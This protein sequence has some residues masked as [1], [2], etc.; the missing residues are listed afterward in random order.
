MRALPDANARLAN[1]AETA[2]IESATS[3]RASEPWVTAKRSGC[4]PVL[5]VGA[6]QAGLVTAVG[7]RSRGISDVTVV[8][9]AAESEAGPWT[10]YARMRTL[11][12]PKDIHWPTW[13]IPSATPRAWFEARYGHA[14][15]QAITLIPT[16]DWQAFLEWYRMTLAIAVEFETT[17]TRIVGG[18]GG[19]PFTV[20][21]SSNGSTRALRADR[22]VLATGLEGSGGRRAP[23]N[24][25]SGIPTDTWAHTHDDIGFEALAG[26]RVGILGGGTGAFDNAATAL[27]AGARSAVVHMR[28]PSMPTVSPYRWMEF[29]GVIEH[30]AEFTDTQKWIF[31]EHLA[32]VDQPATQNAIWRAYSHPAFSFRFSSPWSAVHWNGEEIVVQTPSGEERYDFVIAATGVSVDIRQRSE[33][34]HFADEIALWRDR[35]SPESGQDRYGLLDHPYLDDHFGFVSRDDRDDS[36]LSRIHL[37]NHGAKLSL[38][39]LSH[40]I[41][42]LYGGAERLVRGLVRG[43]FASRSS[44]ILAECLAYDTST[45]VIVGPSISTRP[46]P[47][48]AVPITTSRT[49]I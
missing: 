9:S 36:P 10:S 30:Y 26:A 28:R 27:E 37:F 29:P 15:W 24:L 48:T 14:A 1:L 6:G 25:F 22:I 39:V 38:G 49:A 21:V 4:I 16:E 12:T 35:Y 17:V 2:R 20:T 47:A 43:L 3:R 31:N 13:D 5:V 8:D 46:A 44:D 11:R 41:S 19:T 34:S 45:G 33:L 7:L 42:G 40:Q 32:L 23:A 18:E